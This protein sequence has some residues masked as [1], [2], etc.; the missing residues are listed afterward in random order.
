VR[1]ALTMVPDA[2][3]AELERLLPADTNEA[4]AP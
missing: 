1:H 2:L 3:W 4:I